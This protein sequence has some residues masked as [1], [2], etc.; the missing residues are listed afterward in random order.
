M[1]AWLTGG[2]VVQHGSPLWTLLLFGGVT[3]SAGLW[4]W[5]WQGRH[6]GLGSARGQVN[7]AA[8]YGCLAVLVILIALGLVV[9]GK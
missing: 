6:F 7:T 8:A 1:G 3:A 9:D 4:L 2:Q 5:H